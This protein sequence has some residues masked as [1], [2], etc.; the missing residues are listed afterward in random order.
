MRLWFWGVFGLFAIDRIFNNEGT[1]VL[2]LASMAYTFKD[3]QREYPTDEKCLHK[4]FTMRFL[5]PKCPKCK[6]VNKYHKRSGRPS[7]ICQC[8]KHEISPKRGTIFEKS[9]TDLTKWFYAMFLMSQSRNGVAALELKRHIGVGSY[10][11]ALRMQKQL[12]S[13]MQEAPEFLFGEVE[14]DE[15]MV[16]GRRRG[17]RGRGAQG[18]TIVFG[19]VQRKGKLNAA[20]VPNVI[21]ATLLPDFQNNIAKGTKLMTDELGSYRKIAKFLQIDHDMVQHGAKQYVKGDVHT[22]TIEGFWSQEVQRSPFADAPVRSAA[23]SGSPAARASSQSNRRLSVSSCG[24]SC[25]VPCGGN[26][27][28]EAPRKHARDSR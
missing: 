6:A 28:T 2:P 20:I 17:M 25:S 13:M 4:L 18:K 22:N 1:S 26:S 14:A 15:T 21:A 7:F 16:G 12:R 23:A 9:A 8:G 24:M 19:Q 3:F 10:Q 11:T 5:H 27:A